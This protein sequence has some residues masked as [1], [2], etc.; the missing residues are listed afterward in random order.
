MSDGQ[1]QQHPIPTH[2]LPPHVLL[3]HLIS[4]PSLEEKQSEKE[5]SSATSEEGGGSGPETPLNKSLAKHLLS[6]LGDRLCR[7]LR[8]EREALAWAQREGELSSL[9][10]LLLRGPPNP[11]LTVLWP[12]QAFSGELSPSLFLSIPNTDS[13]SSLRFLALGGDPPGKTKNLVQSS[14]LRTTGLMEETAGASVSRAL[15]GR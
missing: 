13:W 3:L 5:D 12:S 4:R 15:E 6:G 2:G 1:S 10:G 7:L 14:S 9:G 11:R 8:K